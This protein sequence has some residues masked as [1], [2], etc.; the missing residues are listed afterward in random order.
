MTPPHSVGPGNSETLPPHA[1]L[2]LYYKTEAEHQAFLL[3]IFDSTAAD[4]DR[5]E[6]VLAFGTGPSY[7]RDALRQAGLA[8]GAQVLDV[9]IGTGL[10]AREALKLIGSTGQ[11]V[12]VDPSPGMMGQVKLPGVE[13]I[14]GVAENLPRPDASCD[15]VSMGYAMRHISDVAAAFSEFHRVLRPGGRVAVL[16]ITKPEGRVA[17]A[18]LKGYMR[19]VVPLIAR[20]VG[21]QRN[22]S[23]LWRYYWDTIEACIAPERVMQALTAAGFRDVQRH[24]SLG[25]FSCYTAVKPEQPVEVR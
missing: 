21:R 6:S 20:V 16:E 25:V 12:G 22:T 4:Y 24:A 23:E 3:R 5:I 13:L 1:P 17:T 9:G 18:L 8:A 7:R 10:V 14:R 11:L 19:A 15:F 2:P